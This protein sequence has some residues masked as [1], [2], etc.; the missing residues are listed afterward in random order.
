MKYKIGFLFVGL[1]ICFLLI[2][3]SLALTADEYFEF[4]SSKYLEGNTKAALNDLNRALKLEPGHD[5]ASAL[6][7]IILQER[8]T[9]SVP[10]EKVLSSPPQK[11]E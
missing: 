1:L 9:E 5:G 11:K 4:A 7:G 10:L 2:V 8:S 3:P 6:K